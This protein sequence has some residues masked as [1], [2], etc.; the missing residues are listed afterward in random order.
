MG[1]Q[2]GIYGIIDSDL[3][4]ALIWIIVGSFFGEDKKISEVSKGK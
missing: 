2:N 4:A 1:T 3:L